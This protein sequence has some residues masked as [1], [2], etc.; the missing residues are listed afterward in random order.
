MALDPVGFSCPR[1]FGRAAI[2]WGDAS[3]KPPRSRDYSLHHWRQPRPPTQCLI[4]GLNSFTCVMT[5]CLPLLRLIQSVTFLNGRLGVGLVATLC[6]KWTLTIKKQYALLGAPRSTARCSGAI[7][8]HSEPALV[9][10]P[11]FRLTPSCLALP[12]KFDHCFEGQVLFTSF[13]Q[14]YAWEMGHLR[15]S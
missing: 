12:T 6:P 3:L 1:R 8:H 4:S 14:F 10:N 13:T 9:L 11:R 7:E 5:R 15:L 2:V